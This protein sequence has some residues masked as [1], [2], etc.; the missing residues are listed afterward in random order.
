MHTKLDNVTRQLHF[1]AGVHNMCS[2][3]STCLITQT[4]LSQVVSCF[5]LSV[6]NHQRERESKG[7]LAFCGSYRQMLSPQ[8]PSSSVGESVLLANGRSWVQ[9]PV[10]PQVIF[11]D[12][13]TL[14][15]LLI[16]SLDVSSSVS[17]KLTR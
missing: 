17:C 6:A 10:G 9:S 8:V 7:Q 5:R 4:I 13:F 14:S 11:W 15:L 3:Y 2:D 1:L 12:I 16:L